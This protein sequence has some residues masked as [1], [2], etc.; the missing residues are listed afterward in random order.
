L[1]QYKSLLKN[2]FLFAIGSIGSSAISFFMLPLYTRFLSTSDYGQ[3]DVLLT[4]I[5]LLL[6]AVTL[7]I[8]SAVLRFSV[9]MGENDSASS[10]LMN[11]LFMCF[12]GM[13][14]TLLLFPV[15]TRVEPFSSYILFFYLLI[16][17]NM[18]YRVLR[19]FIKGLDKIKT[20]VAADLIYTATFVTLNVVFLVRLKMGLKGYILSM[21][22]AYF[23]SIVIILIFGDIFKYLNFKAFD[24]TFLKIMLIYSSPLVLNEILFWVVSASDRYML[25]YYIGFD[26]T[27]IYSVANKFPAVIS[28]MYGIFSMA[29]QLS[30]MQEYGKEGYE[31][32]FKNIFG[33]L[34]SFLFL[35]AGLIILILK[36]LM[37]IFVSEAFYESRKYVPMLLIGTIFYAFSNFFCVNYTASKK[38]K[39]MFHTTAVGAILNIG[40]NFLLIPIW[41]I[42]AATF[43]TLASYLA[44]WLVRVFDSKK[45]VD[46]KIDWKSISSSVLIIGLQI[47][48]LYFIENAIIFFTVETLLI[49]LLLI[50]Q[51][52]YIKQV[53][54][55][56][57]KLIV[58]LRTKES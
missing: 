18:L 29:W 56:G 54:N 7:Q 4:T 13:V 12:F 58:E 3:L 31:D 41:G 14:L 9:D 37:S 46:I 28:M 1:K 23:V 52:K 43:S 39:G 51:R 6:P 33:V 22:L 10:V 11:G 2:S 48:G 26:A 40:I 50:I 38:T 34:S 5:S 15:F 44:M 47:V 27:G 45:F 8:S 42:Q 20:F 30:A 25:T 36:P 21:V 17:L 24:K 32:F 53:F 16:F 35:L 19:Q 57:R 55:F 49:V